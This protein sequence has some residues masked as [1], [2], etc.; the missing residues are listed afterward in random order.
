MSAV[1]ATSSCLPWTAAVIPGTRVD[2]S[3]V[4]ADGD[5]PAG[6]WSAP[7]Q[8]GSPSVGPGQAGRPQ[9]AG[10]SFPSAAGEPPG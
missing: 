8:G 2:P 3:T 10:P 9:V 7:G 5:R 4:D 1:A 6:A